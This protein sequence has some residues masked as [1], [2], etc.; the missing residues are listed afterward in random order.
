ML[1]KW[2]AHAPGAS[3]YF[4]DEVQESKKD[5]IPVWDDDQTSTIDDA[6]VANGLG[7]NQITELWRLLEEFADVFQNVP[8]RT[9]VAGL[10]QPV[11]LPPY[12]LPHAY[13]DAVKKELQEMLS[14]GIIEPSTSEWSAPIVLVKKKDGSMRLCVDYRR[15]NQISK[16]DAYPMPRVDDLID[17]V[18]KSTYISTLDLTRGYWQVPVAE[19]DRPKTAFATPCIW[20]IPI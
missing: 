4:C 19:I 6:M 10:A 12:R 20:P 5:D 16:S 9:S 3:A 1:R 17:R 14:S 8:G 13:R 18:G 15:F 7:E 11:R 2:H